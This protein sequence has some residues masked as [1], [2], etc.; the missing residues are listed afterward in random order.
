MDSYYF[1]DYDPLRGK[2]DDY[3]GPTTP[4]N[5]NTHYTSNITQGTLVA[6]IAAGSRT[7]DFNGG[8]APDADIYMGQMANLTVRKACL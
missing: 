3:D 2:V 5:P 8:I 7:N 1:K 4:P 6:T